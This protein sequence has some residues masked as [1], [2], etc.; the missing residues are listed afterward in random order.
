MKQQ[1]IEKYLQILTNKDLYYGITKNSYNIYE[2][3]IATKEIQ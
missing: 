1:Y 3:D 2:I